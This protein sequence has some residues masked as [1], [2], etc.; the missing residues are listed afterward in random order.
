MQSPA[1]VMNMFYTGLGIAR[2]LGEQGIPVVGL[3]EQRIYGN[4]TR[5]AKTVFCP[6]SRKDPEALLAFLLRRGERSGRGVIFPTRDDDVLFLDRFRK[7]LEP[8][9]SL[10]VPPS[11]AITVCLDKWQTYLCSKQAGVSTPKSWLVEGEEDLGRAMQEATYPCVL[12]PLAAHHWRR[13]HNW[14]IVGAR[15]AIPVRSR[16]E[17]VAEYAAIARADNRAL[18]QEMIP[19]GDDCLVVTACYI[20]RKFQ[21]A[22]AFNAQKLVQEPAIFGTGCVV[23]TVHRPELFDPTQRL[24]QQMNFSGIAEVEYKW[25]RSANCYKLIEVNPRPWD[26]HRLGNAC[27]V[28]LIHLAYADHADLP[29]PAVQAHTSTWKWIADDAFVMTAVRSLRKRDGKCRA[30]LRTARGKRIYGIWSA[31]DPLPFLGYFVGQLIPQLASAGFKRFWSRLTAR[32]ARQTLSTKGRS[33]V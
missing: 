30:M 15:K 24:L 2:S 32:M 21:W 9:Y 27:G 16:E 31:K 23:Q 28:D 4:Y 26:Q 6:D 29:R 25:D 5:Y 17:L 1:I 11:S 22:G 20:D 7:E 19:G 13:G 8:Y 3:T 18:L 14:D 12:K 10:V 33:A